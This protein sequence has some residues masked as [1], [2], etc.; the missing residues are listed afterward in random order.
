MRPFNHT[1]GYPPHSHNGVCLLCGM[2]E[3]E[4]LHS[5][6]YW[7]SQ[8]G[9]LGRQHCTAA[10]VFPAGDLIVPHFFPELVQACDAWTPFVYG[11][12]F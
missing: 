8:E 7:P 12:P 6:G 4:I 11:I 2:S 5:D 3:F 1:L 9:F 10:L